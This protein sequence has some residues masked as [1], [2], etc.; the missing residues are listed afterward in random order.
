MWPRNDSAANELHKTV[1]IDRRV[2]RRNVG[3]HFL[4][5]F[6]EFHGTLGK[7]N[8]EIFRHAFDPLF[9]VVTL[10]N[11]NDTQEIYITGQLGVL[12]AFG[13]IVGLHDFCCWKVTQIIGW[14]RVR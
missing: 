14:G 9:V 1:V 12:K 7:V 5:R 6:D 8:L 3:V 2:D 11:I 13:V 10:E 4:L